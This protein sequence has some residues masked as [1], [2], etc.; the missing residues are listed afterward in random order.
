MRC[1]CFLG[2]V[3]AAKDRIEKARSGIVSALQKEATCSTPVESESTTERAGG[4]VTRKDEN[5]FKALRTGEGVALRLR[6]CLVACPLLLG[7]VIIS[8]WATFRLGCS[9]LLSEP[10]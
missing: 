3:R 1:R 5:S 2:R 4:L 7:K 9:D 8:L 6:A 10:E